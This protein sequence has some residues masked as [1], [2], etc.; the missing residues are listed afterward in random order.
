MKKALLILA[1]FVLLFSLMFSA[2]AEPE[3][4]APMPE[5]PAPAPEKPAPAPRPDKYGGVLKEVLT[6]GPAT[7]IGYPPE[8]APD[9]QADA[10][11][12]IESLVRIRD[13]GVV[14]PLLATAWEI[15][16][17]GKSITVTL[18]KGVKFH[19]GTDFNAT[20]VKWNLDNMIEA[21]KAP[22]W[23]SVEVIDDYAVRI[24]ITGYR[25]TILTGLGMGTAMIISPTAVEKNG[26]DWARWHPVGT[27]PFKFVEYERDARL[28]YEK[29]E[30]Y[31]NE[32][33]PYLDGVEFIVIAD[34]T[35]RKIA[36]QKG[37]IHTLRASGLT[38]QELQDMGFDYV[39]RSGGTF[40]L[41][42]DSKNAESPFADRRVR[43][44]VSH[45]ID[46]ESLA[47]AL[48]YGFSRPAYQVYPGFT[49]TAIPNLD[50]HEYDPDEA[51]RLLA[52]A[53][54]TGGFK[55]TIHA[56]IRVVPKD[57]VSAIANMLGQVGIEVTPDFPEAGKYSEYRFGGWNN[58]MMAHAMASMENINSGFSFY[59][60]GIQFP[61][62]QKP[63]GWQEAYDAA[64]SSINVDPV[65]TQALVKLMHDDVMIIPYMEET[66][67]AFIREGV[68]DSG[69]L[70]DSL[71]TLIELEIT[72][73]DPELR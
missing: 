7:P 64:L 10:R 71:T 68:N 17:D 43:L 2:C 23:E 39:T 55:T 9:A 48:G 12:A 58:A 41:V 3:E 36:F 42:P 46:R 11:P 70:K 28:V 4:P 37:D 19:D 33:L 32:G 40:M 26:L 53:G 14:E 60:G 63:D 45:A 24:N 1:A 25:N 30:N 20:A 15:T 49:E 31:W 44:A 56:F 59:F 8:A 52:L 51:R 35:V 62:V 6:V 50:I 13:G 29:N 73:L 54:Y 21:K 61:S 47:K 34:E 69:H 38:A 72:W 67:V 5:K 27:G 18:R 16:P 66:A 22:D 65:K 57:Y